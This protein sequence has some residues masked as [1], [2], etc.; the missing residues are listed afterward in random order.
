MFLMG[1]SPS[2]DWAV[3]GSLADEL[4]ALEAAD[5]QHIT[6]CFGVH[7]WYAH[8]QDADGLWLAQLRALLERVPHALLGE[9]GLDRVAVTPDTGR[10]EFA[11]QQAA[12]ARQLDLAACLARP[13]SLHCVRAFGSLFDELRARAAD[14]LPPTLALHSYTGTA[15]FALSL[16]ALPRVGARVYFSFSSVINARGGRAKLAAV[17]AVVPRERVLLE[18]DED[19]LNA[20]PAAMRDIAT[21][22]AEAWGEVDPAAVAVQCATN[23]REFARGGQATAPVA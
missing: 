15:G 22:V 20:Q 14:A 8:V 11:A 10:C 19:D 12:L 9:I 17:L 3:L 4:D 21:L 7:P 5:R 16:L 2:H 6:L 18:S 13:V 23:A 1:V